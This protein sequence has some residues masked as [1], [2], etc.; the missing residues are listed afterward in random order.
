M[1]RKDSKYVMQLVK[2]LPVRMQHVSTGAV[3]D[4][5]ESVCLILILAFLSR[6]SE[7][8]SSQ[9]C[10]CIAANFHQGLGIGGMFLL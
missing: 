7:G 4:S 8:H 1:L 9:A 2:C 6:S 5:V 10:K 3:E